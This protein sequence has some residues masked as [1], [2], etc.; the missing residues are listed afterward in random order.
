M[1]DFLAD[2]LKIEKTAKG[3]SLLYLFTFAPPLLITLYDPRAFLDALEYAGAFGV[4]TLLGLLPVLMVW[5]GRYAQHREGPYRAPGGRWALG[6][7]FGIS[8]LVIG[9]EIAN[10][11][12][13]LS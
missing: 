6:I 12:G 7:A 10:K 3:R 9:L 11:A 8:L 4:V 1:R 5:R 13:V 2:G